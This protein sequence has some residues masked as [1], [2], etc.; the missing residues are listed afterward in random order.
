[1]FVLGSSEF[2]SIACLMLVCNNNPTLPDWFAC[3]AGDA[4]EVGWK[5]GELG[6]F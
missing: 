6:E 2:V 1:M 4:G 5:P 3:E